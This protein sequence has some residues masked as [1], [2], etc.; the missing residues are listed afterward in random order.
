[1][2]NTKHSPRME[3]A[4]HKNFVQRVVLN[5]TVSLYTVIKASITLITNTPISSGRK[6]R[7]SIP[8]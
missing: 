5:D 2:N 3:M 6:F 7:P 1:M 8:V 4:N